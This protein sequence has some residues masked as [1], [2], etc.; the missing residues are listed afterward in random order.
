MD[1]Q[2]AEKLIAQGV[3]PWWAL[4][5]IV[6]VAVLILFFVVVPIVVN[7]YKKRGIDLLPGMKKAEAA[8]ANANE[9]VSC[10]DDYF[11]PAG[12]LGLILQVGEKA[13]KFVEKLWQEGSLP[14]EERHAKAKETIIEGLKLA[15]FADERISSPEVQNII[16]ASIKAAVFD[17]PHT[18]A[19]A[20][21][22]EKV[23]Q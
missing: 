4:V 6:I 19:S 15:G 11:P 8:I 17:L 2:F 20:P 16:D 5:L 22:G 7:H 10:V 21:E 1:A 14:T 12:I 23:P 3:L 9:L 18:T 13:V